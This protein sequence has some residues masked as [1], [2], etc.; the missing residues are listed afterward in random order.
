M[1]MLVYRSVGSFDL[2][3]LRH[4]LPHIRRIPLFCFTSMLKV[5]WNPCMTPWHFSSAKLFAKC[6][7]IY[8][9]S[10]EH[11]LSIA[12]IVKHIKGDE[13]K[14][15]LSLGSLG[16]PVVAFCVLPHKRVT[17]C[18]RVLAKYATSPAQSRQERPSAWKRAAANPPLV[19]IIT[20]MAK[21]AHLLHLI[22]LDF[23]SKVCLESHPS[24]KSEITQGPTQT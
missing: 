6:N 4:M 19:N 7:N 1:A 21:H 2:Q 15:G 3:Q 17:G 18:L 8:P 9:R 20:W 24:K 14:F 10:C 13:S 5:S 23:R 22:N 16:C 11:Y 12:K